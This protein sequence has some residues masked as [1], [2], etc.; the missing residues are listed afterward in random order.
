MVLFNEATANVR[1]REII[2]SEG[3][4][5]SAALVPKAQKDDLSNEKLRPV[6]SGRG[7]ALL[8]KM[9]WKAGQGLGRANDGAVLPVEATIKTDMG[10]LRVD[11]EETFRAGMAAADLSEHGEAALTD[12]FTV[13]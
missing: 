7:F 2:G 6:D 13:N 4:R 11:E 3:I 1:K 12:A 10:G 9:G 8:E 5:A